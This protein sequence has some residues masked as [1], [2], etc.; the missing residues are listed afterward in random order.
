M[1]KS[2]LKEDALKDQQS[3]YCSETETEGGNLSTDILGLSASQDS[4]DSAKSRP[5]LLACVEDLDDD[6]PLASLGH[7]SKSSAKIKMSQLDSLGVRTNASSNHA[8]ASSRDLSKSRDD[9]QHVDRKRVRVVLSD[10]E[11]DDPDEM[12]GSRQKLH[13]S[14]EFVTAPDR[15]WYKAT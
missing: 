3:D 14:S 2:L 10:D 12:Y 5:S 13:R 6:V 15:G 11:A 9:Q 4:D 7:S 8:Q 1:L